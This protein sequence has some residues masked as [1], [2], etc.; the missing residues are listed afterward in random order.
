MLGSNG[1]GETTLRTLGRAWSRLGTLAGVC[2]VVLVC[3]GGLFQGCPGGPPVVVVCTAGNAITECDDGDPCTTDTC[4]NIDADGNGECDNTDIECPTG[5]VC[6]GGTCKTPC[7]TDADCDDG[8]ACTDDACD[9]GFCSDEPTDCDDGNDCTTDTCDAD[10]GCA[11]TPDDAACDDDLF[12]NGEET[13]DAD[14]GCVDGAEPCDAD[15]EVCL[16]ATDDCVPV[17]DT[18]ADCPAN[19]LFCTIVTC[20]EGACLTTARNCDDDIFCNGEETCN[21]D[22]DT[23]DHAGDPCEG[24]AA[25]NCDETLDQC[26]EGEPCDADA[27]CPDDGAFC[28]GTERCG[29][30]DFCESSGNPCV[31]PQTCNEDLNACQDPVGTTL[32]FTLGADNL[33]GTGGAD[34]FRAQLLFNAG[35]GTQIASL[36]NGDAG[37][38]GDGGDVLNATFA[39]NSVAAGNVTVAPTLSGIETV[40]ITD[41]GVPGGQNT[42]FSGVNSTGITTINSVNSTDDAVTVNNLNTLVN[43]GVNNSTSNLNVTLIAPATNGNADAITLTLNSAR[44]GSDV[45]L[46]TPVN[47]VETVTI[48]ST[49]AANTLDSFQH[50]AA[51]LTTLNV[52]GT[53]NLTI[54]GALPATLTTINANAASGATSLLVGGATNLVFTGGTGNDTLNLAGTYATADTINGGTGTNTLGLNSAQAVAATA[55]QSNVT[56]IQTVRIVDALGGAVDV[57]K[58]G[59]TD[60]ILDTTAAAALT[61][62]G[63]GPLTLGTGNRTLTLNNDD[64]ANALTVVVSGV[65]TSDTLALNLQNSDLG[66]ALTMTGAETVN[67]ASGNGADGTAA[68][69]NVTT[70]TD[71]TMTPTIGTGTLNFSGSVSVNVTGVITAGT[72][73]ASTLGAAFIHETTTGSLGVGGSVAGSAFNDEL[74][75]SAANDGITGG[76]GNDQ[77]K[78][79]NGADINTGGNGVDRFFFDATAQFGDTLIDFTGGTDK[80][81][82]GSGIVNFAAIAGTEAVPVALATGNFETARTAVTTLVAGDALKIVRLTTEQTTVQLTTGTGAAGAVNLYVLAF[83]STIGRGVLYHDADW[84]DAGGRTLVARFENIT[85]NAGVQALTFTDFEEI[86]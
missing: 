15:D 51:T 11:N 85:T 72:V 33:L 60:A 20:T 2:G 35:T 29:S 50:A 40:N 19:N 10:T 46:N 47:G 67:A 4:E 54:T 22:T 1:T 64:T 3:W 13:C 24:T 84:A 62:A 76:D 65:G 61:G 59:A 77:I 56:N 73:N 16:E 41:F 42:T 8:D 70:A 79:L 52:T 9:D 44:V 12:C 14:T 25:P 45:I 5:Q 75:G 38:G 74:V 48:A 58:F 34:T 68:D 7:D 31:A 53:Q 55:A 27:D 18:V 30:D 49:G 23:C 83:D 6:D 78:G 21:E 86:D 63:A 43:L 69:G 80:V 36:Q 32:D 57:T 39:E 17:C 71:I 26:T 82:L 37:T 81:G 66:A 28:N